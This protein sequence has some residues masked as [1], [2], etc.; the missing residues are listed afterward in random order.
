V[1]EYSAQLSGRVIADATN[2][3]DLS[4]GEPLDSEWIGPSGSAGQ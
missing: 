4:V 3:V 1:R 2:S